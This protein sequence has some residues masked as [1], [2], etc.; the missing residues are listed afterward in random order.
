MVVGPMTGQVQI[1]IFLY[2]HQAF[3]HFQFEFF[4]QI[5]K[6]YFTFTQKQIVKLLFYILIL[7]ITRQVIQLT[8]DTHFQNLLFN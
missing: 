1:Q 5:K 8:K 2:M 7:E 4:P 3:K 6:L